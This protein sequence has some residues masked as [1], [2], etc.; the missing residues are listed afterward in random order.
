[1]RAYSSRHST[2]IRHE[3]EV[4]YIEFRSSS[5]SDT[6]PADNGLMGLP[7]PVTR[8]DEGAGT[9]GITYRDYFE[10]IGRAIV[11][12]RKSFR[13]ALSKR[14]AHAGVRIERVEIWPEKHGSDYHPARIRAI[15]SCGAFSFVMN[16][17]FTHRGRERLPGEFRTLRYLSRRFPHR[18]VPEVYFMCSELCGAKAHAHPAATMFLAEWLEGYYEFHLSRS[19]GGDSNRLMLWNTGQGHTP[20]SET[21]SEEIFRQA[22]CLLTTCYDVRTFRE[23]F[24]WHHASGDFVAGTQGGNIRVKLIAARQYAP[25]PVFEKD[26]PENGMTALL[27]FFANLTV[28]MRLDRIDGVGEVTWAGGH[29]LDA[30]IRGFLDALSNK[31]EQRKCSRTLPDDF[32]RTVRAMSPAELAE[33][34]GLVADSYHEGAP[35]V[36]VIRAN[37]VDHVLH[38]YK[39][40]R[41]HPVSR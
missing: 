1:M 24:P 27:A 20:V 41:T 12:R 38:V 18:F 19:G 37:L 5:L 17:A 21:D 29:C 32:R 9:R 22:A 39:A 33:F 30:T 28:R 31:A 34:F 13:K 8:G 10:A 36:P 11:N 6:L 16:V 14:S 15:T 26:S 2:M 25:R 35:D 3:E 4:P 40:F 23:V 7:F